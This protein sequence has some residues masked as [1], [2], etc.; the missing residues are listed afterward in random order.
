MRENRGYREV[1]ADIR[2]TFNV[3]MLNI[4]QTAQY[5]NCDAKTVRRLIEGKKLPA[6]DLSVKQNKL[7]RVPAETLARFI[8]K[9][10]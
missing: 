1:M 2:S 9:E 8:T 7:Y 5:L 10:N 6:I 3:G 4:Q